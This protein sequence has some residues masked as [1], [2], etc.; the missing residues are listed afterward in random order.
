MTEPQVSIILPTHNGQ[1]HLLEAVHSC[2]DQTLEN[3]ELIVVDDASSDATAELL[4]GI[5]D[6]R[7]RIVSNKHNLGL[8]R[9]L[10]VGFALARGMFLTWTSDDNLYSPDALEVMVE[11][12]LADPKIGMVY[13]DYL[14]IDQAG[15]TVKS[16]EVAPPED[17]QQRNVVGACFLYRQ[18][19][20]GAVG[21]YDPAMSLAEDYDYWVR[22]Q[23]RF[24]MVR[25]P[26]TLYSYRYHVAALTAKRT[27]EV[28]AAVFQV[29]RR[30]FFN[31]LSTAQWRKHVFIDCFNRSLT[32]IK[33]KRFGDLARGWR[34]LGLGPWLDRENLMYA[35]RTAAYSMMGKSQ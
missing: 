19:V 29:Q 10:N 8:P 15:Y 25:I 12:L 31:E 22:V 30:H 27:F 5:D 32:A 3:L 26:K 20:R 11:Q 7:L 6:P 23:Q 14:H 4:A 18:E 21:E 13:A 2:L 17:M 24:E 1:R 16:V 35:C 33:Q 28:S 9:S 34:R